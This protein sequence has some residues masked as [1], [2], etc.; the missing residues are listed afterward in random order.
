LKDVPTSTTEDP[1]GFRD[2]AGARLFD[3]AELAVEDEEE[4][5]QLLFAP[6]EVEEGREGVDAT[7][8]G[9]KNWRST[10]A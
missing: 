4:D 3:F 7:R 10:S 8:S 2:F 6:L 1:S 5:F 9:V